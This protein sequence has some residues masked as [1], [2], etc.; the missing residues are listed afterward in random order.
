[1]ASVF[2]PHISI[3]TTNRINILRSHVKRPLFYANFNQTRMVGL[4]TIFSKILNGKF[5]E[6]PSGY[7]Q[8]VPCG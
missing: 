4:S 6:N 5:H 2:I 7:N 3:A 8:G 1:L